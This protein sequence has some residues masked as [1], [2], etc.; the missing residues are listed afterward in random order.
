MRATLIFFAVLLAV[1]AGY[2]A[3]VRN[4]SG[5]EKLLTD[6]GALFGP[7]SPAPPHPDTVPP[8]ASAPTPPQ[9][10][11]VAAPASA[12]APAVPNPPPPRIKPWVPP[13]VMPSQP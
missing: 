5:F 13:D 4:P 2:Y 6:P 9:Q 11:T 7:V 12:S 10:P 8:S 3:Y 1:L